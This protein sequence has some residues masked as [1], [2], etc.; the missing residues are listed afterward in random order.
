[1]T[2]KFYSLKKFYSDYL[3]QATQPC[4]TKLYESHSQGL[5]TNRFEANVFGYASPSVAI[6]KLTDG[7]VYCIANNVEWR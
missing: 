5:S 4:W 6:F 1:M 7:K 2:H 3:Q